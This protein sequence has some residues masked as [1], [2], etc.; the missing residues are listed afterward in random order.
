MPTP[1]DAQDDNRKKRQRDSIARSQGSLHAASS[2]DDK[3]ART[4]VTLSAQVI[5]LAVWYILGRALEE[6]SHL[7][8]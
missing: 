7:W 3:F 6:Y 2:Q 4:P 5:G 1:T 8:L